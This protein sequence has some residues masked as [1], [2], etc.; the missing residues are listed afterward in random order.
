MSLKGGG[1]GDCCSIQLVGAL[2]VRGKDRDGGQPPEREGGFAG[3]GKQSQQIQ[4]RK[5]WLG[6]GM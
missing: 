1:M 3:L 5:G 6:N 2:W 4:Q